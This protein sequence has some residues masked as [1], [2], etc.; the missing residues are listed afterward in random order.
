MPINIVGA[1]NG[2]EPLDLWAENHEDTQGNVLINVAVETSG[3]G[4]RVSG[5]KLRNI[6]LNFLTSKYSVIELDF[7]EVNM[8]SSSFAD[9]LIGKLISKLGFLGFTKHIKI[10]N[11]NEFNSL[12]INRSVGQRMAQIY[13]DKE[14]DELE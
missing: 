11:V 10:S 2:Y 12:I 13:M 1:L 4:T 7:R 3:T 14:I 6:V 5:E 8:L 9:E